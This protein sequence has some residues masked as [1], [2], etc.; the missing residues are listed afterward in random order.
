MLLQCRRRFAALF[1][2]RRT[3][4]VVLVLAEKQNAKGVF[5]GI[6][7][8][9]PPGFSGSAQEEQRLPPFPARGVAQV[10]MVSGIEKPPKELRKRGGRLSRQMVFLLLR[11]RLLLLLL[12]GR[13]R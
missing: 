7:N 3:S 11:Q 1:E 8:L 4:L 9:C 2:R 13:R 6:P 5:R 12:Q 10:V